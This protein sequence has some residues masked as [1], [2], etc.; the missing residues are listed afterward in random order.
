MKRVIKGYTKVFKEKFKSRRS[1]H[2]DKD[3]QKRA[4]AVGFATR[5]DLR[6][7]A[8]WLWPK[9]QRNAINEKKKKRGK[10]NILR[11]AAT[12]DATS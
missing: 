9:Y 1:H 6:V 8:K 12:D 5:S 7:C 11:T 4:C 3:P 10:A 2:S